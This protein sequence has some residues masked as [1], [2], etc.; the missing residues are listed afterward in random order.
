MPALTRFSHQ[1]SS[2]KWAE[3]GQQPVQ[4]EGGQD[5]HPV[6]RQDKR[7]WHQDER[8]QRQEGAQYQDG[9]DHESK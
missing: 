9:E 2:V 8:V 5:R 3:E 1:S 4:Q 7:V 6:Q